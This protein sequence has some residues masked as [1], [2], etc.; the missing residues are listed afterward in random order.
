[1]YLLTGRS[2]LDLYSPANDFWY[3][4]EA[5]PAGRKLSDRLGIVLDRLLKTPIEERFPS[6]KALNFHLLACQ[7]VRR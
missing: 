7:S 2:P 4:R 5:L 6:A 1:M 3:W